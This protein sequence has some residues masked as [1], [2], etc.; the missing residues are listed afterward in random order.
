MPHSNPELWMPESPIDVFFFDCDS[1]LSLIE[2]IDLLASMNGVAEPVHEITQRCMA[3]TGLT[4]ADYRKRLDFIK[5]SK[6]Q[7]QQLATMYGRHL[8][9]G[10]TDVI[11]LLHSLGKKIYIISGGI[12]SAILP[13]AEELGIKPSRLLA[14]DVYFNDDG[15]YQGFDEQNELTQAN[16]KSI[17][18]ANVLKDNERSLLLGDGFSDWEAQT[19]VTRFVGYAGLHPKA[20]VQE[21]SNF[22]ILHTNITPVLALGLT[23][24]EQIN[25]VGEHKTSYDQG[26]S[27]IRKGLVLIKEPVDVHHPNS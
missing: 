12:K 14:V 4:L 19:T 25:L 18:I 8:A 13:L 9:P 17:C 1:T 3:T 6:I 21:H 2:G 26:L 15:S 24:E 10:A 16:G 22:Y 11:R 7:V 23:N 20:W 27:A 5:P